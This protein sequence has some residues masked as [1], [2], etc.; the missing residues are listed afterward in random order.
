[1]T[2]PRTPPPAGEPEP[3]VPR[4]HGRTLWRVMGGTVLFHVVAALVLWQV[5]QSTQTG[6]IP[7]GATGDDTAV[8]NVAT[9]SVVLPLPTVPHGP[10]AAGAVGAAGSG[11]SAVGQA[12]SG[13]RP[14]GTKTNWLAQAQRK[15]RAAPWGLDSAGNVVWHNK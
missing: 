8:A 13:T 2:Q 9:V 12:P 10:V 1:M 7:T 11:G 14:A 5:A 3:L 6:A 4:Q 15:D